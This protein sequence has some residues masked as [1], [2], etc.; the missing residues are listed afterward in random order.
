MLQSK[1]GRERK[2]EITCSRHET[3]HVR[4]NKNKEKNGYQDMILEFQK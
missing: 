3:S 4:C 1:V 2:K